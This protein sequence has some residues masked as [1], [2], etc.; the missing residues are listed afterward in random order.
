M[1]F[2]LFNVFVKDIFLEKKQ[3]VHTFHFTLKKIAFE[4]KTEDLL[5]NQDS[6]SLSAYPKKG[7][8]SHQFNCSKQLFK[9]F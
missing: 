9:V 1:L 6:S 4:R 5:S 7:K 8:M 3:I 2:D